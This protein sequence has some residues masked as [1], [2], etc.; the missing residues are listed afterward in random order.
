[1]TS[2]TISDLPKPL[3]RKNETIFMLVK[4]TG[5]LSL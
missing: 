1:M 4:R 5:S 2:E 3:I